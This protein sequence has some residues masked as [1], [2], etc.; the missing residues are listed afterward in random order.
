MGGEKLL[1]DHDKQDPPQHLDTCSV[2]EFED[3]RI[4]GEK[5]VH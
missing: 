1:N 4:I 3:G 5:M 2:C